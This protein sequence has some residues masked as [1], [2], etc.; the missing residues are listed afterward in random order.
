MAPSNAPQTL[1]E[2][3]AGVWMLRRDIYDLDSEW[4]GRFQGQ[5]TFNLRGDD[6]LDYH[7]E[8]KLA[9]GGLTAMTATRD[10]SWHFP[11]AGRV[12]VAFDDGRPFHEFDAR[13]TRAEASHYCDPDDYAVT[14]DFAKWPEWRAEWRVEGPRKDY[15]MVSIFT[16]P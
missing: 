6:A 7:E 14:Y 11:G 2:K 12:A 8:G 16:R 1:R 3:F 4:I 10:Y 13:Q 15:R 5:A 9:F